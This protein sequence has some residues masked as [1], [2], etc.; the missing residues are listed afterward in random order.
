M[1]LRPLTTATLILLSAIVVAAVALYRWQS[2]WVQVVGGAVL[3]TNADGRLVSDA[4]R[5]VLDKHRHYIDNPDGSRSSPSS[6]ESAQ[7]WETGPS[8]QRITAKVVR[9]TMGANDADGHRL[10][11]ER[12][13]ASRSPTLVFVEFAGPGGPQSIVVELLEELKTRGISVR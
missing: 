11:F 10:A 5:A 9:A 12:I 7:H 2:P 3:R 13:E 1:K 8:P 4:T 6:S